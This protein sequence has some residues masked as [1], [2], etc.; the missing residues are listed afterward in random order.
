M[1][2]AGIAVATLGST[3]LVLRDNPFAAPFVERSTAEIARAAD[4]AMARAVTADWL[5]PRLSQALRAGDEDAVSFYAALAV[6]HHIP[7]PQPLSEDLAAFRAEQSG[8]FAWISD[9][10]A[11]AYDM[12]R[13]ASVQRLAICALPVEMTPLGDLNALRRGGAAYLSG[14]SPDRLETGLAVVGLGATAAAVATGG[15]GLVVKAGATTLRLAHRLGRITPGLSRALTEGARLPLGSGARAARSADVTA[16]LLRL[17]GNAGVVPTLHLL[18]H[19]DSAE[20]AARI[21]RLSDAAG[22]RT[23]GVVEVLGKSR[24]LRLTVRL[25]DRVLAAMALIYA[26]VLQLA[27]WVAGRLGRAA[28]RALA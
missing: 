22:P 19:I 6:D 15:G 7:L 18:R 1:L 17:G 26:L 23:R 24:A 3:I 5:L 12:T 4:R 28:L 2:S 9:C 20:D 8:S 27:L 16:D 14:Q 11:C 13:C 21:A 25:A 10:A